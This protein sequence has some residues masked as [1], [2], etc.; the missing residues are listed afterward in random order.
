MSPQIIGL[1]GFAALMVLILLRVP[2]AV[3][4][5]L[6]GVAGYAAIDGWERAF[7]VLGAT[8]FDLASGYSLSVVPL[9]ILMGVVAARSGMSRE[10]FAAANAQFAG[11]RGA[12]AMATIGACAG[13]GAICGSSLATAATMT[14]IAVPEMR[15]YGYDERLAAASVASGGTLG[16]LIPP[17][18]ILV[19]YAIIAEE[20]VPQLFAAALIPGVLAALLHVAVIWIL[21]R[22]R[23]ELAPPSPVM[24]WRERLAAIAGMWKIGVLFFLAVVGIYLGWFSPTEAAAVGAFGAIVIAAATRAITLKELVGAFLE[25]VAT[26]AMLFFVVLGAFL[27]AYFVVQ[28]QLPVALVAWVEGLDLAPALV[29]L[30]LVVFYIALGCYL[31]SISMILITVPVFLPLAVHL[32]YSPVWF[33]ILLVVVVEVGLITPPVGMNIFVIRAQ[34]P[35]IPLGAVYRGIVPFLA[36]DAALV[37]LLLAVPAVALWLPGVLY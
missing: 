6:V 37:L 27:F 28:T 1:L 2:V 36:A 3:A 32:G 12:L 5:G 31:D 35:D 9:F 29:I 17:S 25:T 8:P 10:L 33:G 23:P 7:L 26:T 16:I 13:F 21:V 18:V 20:S 30:A 22:I 11:R 34:L 4:L 15:R 24:P 19:I 14:R